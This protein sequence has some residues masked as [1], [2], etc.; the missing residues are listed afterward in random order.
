MGDVADLL[1][2]KL[3]L[4]MTEGTVARW[5]VAPGQRF[6]EGDIIVVIETDKIAND[7]EAPAA[8]EIT[9]LL[10]AEGDVLPVGTPIA[11]WRLDGVDARTRAATYEVPRSEAVEVAASSER[12]A[13]S[14]AEFKPSR[15]AGDRIIA[16]PY[17]RRLARE[18]QIDLA[19]VAGSGPRGRIKADDVLQAKAA[20]VPSR[21]REPVPAI[22]ERALRASTS[23]VSSSIVT[24]DVDV[25]A[26]R[27]LDARL[28]GSRERAFDRLAYIALACAKVLVGDSDERIRL[29]IEMNGAA[30]GV[31]LASRATLSVVAARIAEAA[32]LPQNSEVALA[33]AVVEGR[34]RVLMP[35]LPAG[36]RMALGVGGVHAGRGSDA[37]YEMTLAVTYDDRALD[38]A[39]AAQFLDRIAALLEEPLYLLAA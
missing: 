1:M 15:E 5:L 26:L 32:P 28:A 33:I 36:A 20:P 16:T 13:T 9:A 21:P 3:G 11:Q 24:A 25:S 29:R 2:P 12:V 30:F 37:A 7:V 34:T 17:A 38:H 10:S 6:G 35:A 14:A 31:Q 8:G 27:A 23:S 19:L 39:S 18:A 22:A 4:T